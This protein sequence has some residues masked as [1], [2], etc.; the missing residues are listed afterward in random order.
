[1]WIK[2]KPGSGKSTLLQY[3]LDN[4]EKAPSFRDGDL[5]LSFLFHSRGN[6]LPKTPLG[7]FRS[8]LYQILSRVP[9]A[10]PNVV[11]NFQKWCDTIRKPYQEYEWG[12]SE[13]LR[14][15]DSSLLKIL[16]SRSIWLFVDA[17][18]EGDGDNAAYTFSHFKSMLQTSS[19]KDF[20]IR[21]YFTCRHYPILDIGNASSICLESENKQDI[22][23]YVQDQLSV[24]D[25]LV[26]SEIPNL[27]TKRAE[28]IFMWV[29]RCEARSH[30]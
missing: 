12:L 24:S 13:L 28:G 4:R 30:S 2:G 29:Y 22:L 6:E 16:E 9:D 8:L 25:E 3:A 11:A 17:L 21:I 10:L 26:K 27:I 19:P 15:L 5:I 1:M 7:L 20:R 14:F 23:T 18:D